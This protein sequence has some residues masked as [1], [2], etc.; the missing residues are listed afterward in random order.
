MYRNI[1]RKHCV[2]LVSV[3]AL[4]ALCNSMDQKLME[5]QREEEERRRELTQELV[6]Y[7]EMYQRSEDSRDADIN[8]NHQGR[9][10]VSLVNQEALGPASMQVF[11]VF[12]WFFE[13]CG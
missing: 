2:V 12:L 5:Q 8:Y 11:Q 7:W 6:Q 1:D 3:S 10:N 4:D 9:P 13:H